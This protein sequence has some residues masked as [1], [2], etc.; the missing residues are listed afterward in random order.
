MQLI[1]ASFWTAFLE[2]LIVALIKGLFLLEFHHFAILKM[3]LLR[4]FHGC[5]AACNDEFWSQTR[6]YSI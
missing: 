1:S 2:R 3:F 4:S 6:Y 5:M